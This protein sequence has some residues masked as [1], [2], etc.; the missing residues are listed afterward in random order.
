M[1][2]IQSRNLHLALGTL[3]QGDRN[4]RWEVTGRQ[5]AGGMGVLRE[6]CDSVARLSFPASARGCSRKPGRALRRRVLDTQKFQKRKQ[7]NTLPLQAKR[8]RAP[9]L[10][11][12]F[13]CLLLVSH[14]KQY[15]LIKLPQSQVSEH[16]YLPSSQSS[17]ILGACLGL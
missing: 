11:D 6:F 8:Q 12:D 17:L 5:G 13:H 16:D 7:H 3:G 1:E 2:G 14:G 9:N 10:D 4:K 15:F